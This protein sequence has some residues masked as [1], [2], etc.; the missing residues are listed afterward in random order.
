MQAMKKSLLLSVFT[1]LLSISAIAQCDMYFPLKAGASFEMTTYNTKEEPNGTVTYYIKEVRNNGTEADLMSEVKDKKGKVQSTATYTVLCKGTEMNID[2]KAL[3]PA[4]TMDGYKDMDVKAKGEGYLVL[5]SALTVGA[6]L[7]DATMSWDISAQGQTTVM[8]T[9]SM[10]VTNRKVEAKETITV[11]AGTF[12]CYK[13]TGNTRME[14]A[15]FGLKVPIEMKTIEYFAP[16]V[17]LVKSIT[18]NKNDKLQGST[19]LSKINN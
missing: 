4:A 13:I 6:T 9:L 16:G 1:L 7:P 17:G 5:P 18:Y 10:T 11:P 3:V 14:T 19:A 12:E 8:T 15:T 2:I